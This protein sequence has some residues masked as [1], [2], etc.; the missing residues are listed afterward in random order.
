MA[1]IAGDLERGVPSREPAPETPRLEVDTADVSVVV[2]HYETPDYLERCLRS[3]RDSEDVRLEVFVI[4]NASEHFSASDCRKAYP[5]AT[6]LE[7]E[8]NV[9]FAAASNQGMRRARGRYF[10]LLNPDATVEPRSIR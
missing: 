9:G 6:V 5:A 8:T 3:L 4:D 10:L 2:V 1:T 7:N